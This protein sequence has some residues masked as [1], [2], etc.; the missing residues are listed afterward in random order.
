ML[1][2][3]ITFWKIYFLTLNFYNQ[4]FLEFRFW[5]KLLIFGWFFRRSL[6]KSR[7]TSIPTVEAQAER[8]TV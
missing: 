2:I 4:F 8:P 7:R 6:A 1:T 5:S 3:L